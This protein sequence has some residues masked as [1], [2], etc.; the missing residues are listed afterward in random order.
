MSVYLNYWVLQTFA[1]LLTGLLIPGLKV[2]GPFGAFAAVVGLAFFNATV[3]DAALFFSIPDSLTTHALVLFLSNGMLFWIFVKL[4]PGI[5]VEGVTPALVAPLVFTF[6]SILIREYG[7]LID[8]AA[9]LDN[10]LRIVG[11]LKD[12]LY[13]TAP[14]PPAV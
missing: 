6:A 13:Q 1:M 11:S 3:W 9:V 5:G 4:M 14:T 12:Y 10:V 2:S 7:G 8:W